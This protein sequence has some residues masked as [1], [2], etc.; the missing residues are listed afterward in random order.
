MRGSQSHFQLHLLTVL[1]IVALGVA[2]FVAALVLSGNVPGKDSTRVKALTPTAASLAP[3]AQVVMAGVRVGRVA[4]V[5]LHDAGT[6]V[7]LDIEDQRVLPLPEDSTVAIRSRTAIGENYVAITRGRSRTPLSEDQ[8]LT[9]NRDE[10]Y[11]DVDQILSVLQGETQQRARDFI[12]SSGAALHG[13]GEALNRTVRGTSDFITSS[14]P[15]LTALAQ[16]RGHVA[17]VVG[18]VG[19]LADAVSE[20]DAAV[21][22]VARDGLVT[23]RSL[24]SRD[25]AVRATLAELPPTLRGLRGTSNAL[26]GASAVA[27]PVLRDAGAAAKTLT[28][29]VRRLRPTAQTGRALVRSLDRAIDPL[30]TTLARLRVAAPEV[31]K[32]V[33]ALRQ[34]TCELNPMLRYLTPYTA[35]VLATVVGLGSAANSYD[36][37]GHLIRLSPVLGENTLA[38]MPDSVQAAT[39]TLTHAG[40]LSK[41]SPLSWNPYPKPGKT[42]TE[43]AGQG[44]GPRDAE[45]LKRSGY[46]YPRIKADC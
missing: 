8:P 38:G 17:S 27:T 29:A 34:V 36:A 21:R 43:A 18:R 30:T 14:A 11:V 5:A 46:E 44:A 9:P 32:S 16:D 10:E 40:L 7:D 1:A 2:C 15:V 12:R 4:G 20:R 39:R 35:D 42:G 13:R 41:V 28:P 24:A 23:F 45:D 25:A 19:E 33:P 31:S 26:R 3:G 37:L 6:V 22:S